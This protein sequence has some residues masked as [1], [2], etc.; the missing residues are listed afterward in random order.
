MLVLVKVGAELSRGASSGSPTQLLIRLDKGLVAASF[1]FS[2]TWE[3]AQVRVPSLFS[4]NSNL[5]TQIEI[6][7]AK[8]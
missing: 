1:G 2:A 7:L 3:A 8:D 4:F 5:Y 6:A